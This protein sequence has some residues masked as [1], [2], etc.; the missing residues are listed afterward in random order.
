MHLMPTP[1]GRL[2]SNSSRGVTLIELVVTL[3]LFGIL[4]AIAMPSLT[5]WIR[6]NQIRTVADSLQNGI[7]SAQNEAIRR[8]RVVVFFLTYATP[9][10]GATAAVG[11]RNWAVQYVPTAIDNVTLAEPVVQGGRMSEGGSSNVLVSMMNGTTPVA[12][13]CFNSSGRLITSSAAVTGITGGDCTAGTINVA[14]TQ[15]LP[16]PSSD[17]PLNLRVDLGGRVRMCD[18]NRPSTAPDGC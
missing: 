14:I 8:N 10:V 7:R 2:P 9:M 6:N 18:P 11:G 12:A 17:R 15:A 3:A 1:N 5:G 16:N 13:I 4:F